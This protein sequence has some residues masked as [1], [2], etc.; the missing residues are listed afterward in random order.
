V[1]YNASWSTFGGGEKYSCALALA[2]AGIGGTQVSLLVDSPGVT[3]NGLEEYFHL[4]LSSVEVVRGTRREALHHLDGADL[5]IIVSNVY[6]MRVRA[7]RTM[8]VLQIPYPPFTPLSLGAKFARGELRDA[9]KDLLRMQLL[10]EA[11]TADVSLVYS[12]FV[13]DALARHH[14]I[15]ARVLYPPI[16]DFGPVGNKRQVILSVGRFFRGPYND[17]RYDVLVDAFKLLCDRSPGLSWEYRIVGSCTED[18]PS[19]RYVERLREDAAG[20]PVILR[21]NAPYAELRQEYQQASVFWHAAGYGVDEH[22]H[23]DRMEHFGMSTVEAM[24]AGCIPVVANAGGQREIVAH[25][26]TGYLWTT[27]EELIEHTLELI[28][29]PSTASA[30]RHAARHRAAD[31]SARQFTGRAQELF[32][33]LGV[34]SYESP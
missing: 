3:V 25:G 30:M 8:Y 33:S 1:L 4:D 2:A 22:R 23:P 24:S 26:S 6:P 10:R 15:H 34:G 17:K 20:Y 12:D 31:F 11:R 9:A 27:R 13:R 28:S 19:R 18:E 14:G 7:R 29:G 21:V 16:D 32:H 5:G